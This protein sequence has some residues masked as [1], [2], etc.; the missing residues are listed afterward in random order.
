MLAWGGRGQRLERGRVGQPRTLP[1]RAG[2]FWGWEGRL[3]R[4]RAGA[5]GGWEGR[6]RLGKEPGPA[7]RCALGLQRSAGPRL[8]IE[9][10]R[11]GGGRG[12]LAVFVCL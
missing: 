4:P 9:T 8:E 12:R 2:G 1:P 10:P 6:V 5:G 11:G 3:G 7:L